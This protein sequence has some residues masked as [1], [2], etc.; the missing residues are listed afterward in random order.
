[1]TLIYKL[2][3]EIILDLYNYSCSK[4]GSELLSY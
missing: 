2:L 4:I 1:M 3:I